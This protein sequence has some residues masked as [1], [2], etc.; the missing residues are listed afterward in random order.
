LNDPIKHSELKSPSTQEWR[1]A[2]FDARCWFFL[3]PW[4]LEFLN[5]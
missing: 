2:K 5:S 1:G 3:N 4:L